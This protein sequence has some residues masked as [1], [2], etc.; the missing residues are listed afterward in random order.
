[1]SNI[2]EIWIKVEN[3]VEETMSKA[4]ADTAAQLY[5]EIVDRTPFGRPE[6]WKSKTPPV[7][8]NPGQLRKGWQIDYGKGFSHATAT[9]TG[10]NQSIVDAKNYT[11]GSTITIKNDVDYA[12]AIEFGH[13]KV[14]APQGMVRVSIAKAPTFLNKAAKNN[15]I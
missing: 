3:L 4:V 12:E 5:K 13:S 15:K 11:L 9:F 7:G 1:M 6:L 2:D 10:K 8:Y 14:Q